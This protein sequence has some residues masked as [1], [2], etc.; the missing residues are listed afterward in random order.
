[1]KILP[2]KEFRE[3]YSSQSEFDP[4]TVAGFI[5]KYT[6]E[7][8]VPTKSTTSTKLHELG[9]E[10]LEHLPRTFK[11]YGKGKK[12]IQKVYEPYTHVVDEEIEAEMYS[13]RMRSKKYTPMVGIKALNRLVDEG[14]SLHRALSLV[15]GRLRKYGIKTTLKDE[16]R[17]VSIAKRAWQDENI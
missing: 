1:M 7:P 6:F 9:H 17:I 14:W 2:Q 5:D 15:K 10:R 16:E 4:S 8:V 13:F 11:F 12:D 3:L